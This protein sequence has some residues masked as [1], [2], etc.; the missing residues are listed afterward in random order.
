MS[1]AGTTALLGLLKIG[2]PILQAPMAGVSSPAMAAEVSNAGGLGAIG[3]GAAGVEGARQMIREVRARSSGPLNVNVFAHR[4]ALADAEREAA[5]I[6][7]LRAR[8]AE[9]GGSPPRQLNEIYTS[10]AA[11]DAMLAMLLEERPAVVSLHF[12][13]A[14]PARLRALREAGTVLLATATSLAEARRAVEAGVHA[15]VAQGYEAG[16]HRGVFD[17]YGPDDELGTIALTRLLA[18]N[19]DVPIIAAG[20]IMD[21]RGIT[22][23]LGLG[24]AA[25]QLGTAYVPTDE[26]LADEGYRAALF[27]EAAQHTIMTRAISGRPARSLANRFT[28]L[29]AGIHEA[30]IPAYPIAYDLAKALHALAR[31]AGEFG[32]G[33]QW[34]GQGAPLARRMS[35]GMLT[36]ALASEMR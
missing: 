11:D 31:K 34:A 26:S 4:P 30:D 32:Y 12:G 22:A 36:R 21:G 10:F 13:L 15:I 33:A 18:V 7:R 14:D 17:P 24:A 1:N 20:G 23:A 19:L 6:E 29:A 9:L 16:G 28:A 5:W 35:A 2:L 8:F 27:S 25:G 3:V